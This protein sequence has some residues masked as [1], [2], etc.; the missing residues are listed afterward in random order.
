LAAGETWDY[1]W[2]AATW[3]ED[4]RDWV[5]RLSDTETLWGLV[6]ILDYYGQNGWEL[7]NMVP[8]TWDTPSTGSTGYGGSG[9]VASL[10]TYEHHTTEMG[11]QGG[12]YVHT[13]RTLK[14]RVSRYLCVFKRRRA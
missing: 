2:I 8:Q 7:V 11:P 5:C 6:Q 3:D 4:A 9:S 1:A 10:G 14:W 12:G 13:Y